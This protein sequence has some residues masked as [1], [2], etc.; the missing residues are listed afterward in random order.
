MA[1]WS[2][3]YRPMTNFQWN[4]GRIAQERAIEPPP[5]DVWWDEATPGKLG[6]DEDTKVGGGELSPFRNGIND[7]LGNIFGNPLVGSIA[8]M[9]Y[10]VMALVTLFTWVAFN[11]P[12]DTP[13]WF[14]VVTWIYLFFLDLLVLVPPWLLPVY[15]RVPFTFWHVL[16]RKYHVG[17]SGAGCPPTAGGWIYLLHVLVTL[18]AHA[19]VWACLL[20]MSQENPS[21]VWA[22][23]FALLVVLNTVLH[24]DN[25]Y[26]NSTSYG[27]IAPWAITAAFRMLIVPVVCLIM[28]LT[29]TPLPYVCCDTT[30]DLSQL[31]GR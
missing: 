31:L 13:E 8:Y 19:G 22:V 14:F 30:G 7:W 25:A 10:M 29:V 18:V 15:E 11:T 20:A 27:A 12:Y 24:V 3:A 1:T 21:A 28:I 17:A 9:T 5:V 6:E 23:L 16:E 2:S 4:L 26:Q